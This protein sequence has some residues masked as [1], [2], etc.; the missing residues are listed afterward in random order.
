MAEEHASTDPVTTDPLSRDYPPSTVAEARADHRNWF[1]EALP[2]EARARFLEALTQAKE[3]GLSGDAAWEEAVVAA[4][5]AYPPDPTLPA[6]APVGPPPRIFRASDD[7][8][9]REPLERE[10]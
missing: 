6:D 7:E 4:E 8:R 5:T 2:P 1:Y 9:E 3:R 10:P